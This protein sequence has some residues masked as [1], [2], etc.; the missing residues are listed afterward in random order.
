MRD[1]IFALHSF[2][3]KNG[4]NES[5]V[6]YWFSSLESA[7]EYLNNAG[8]WTEDGYRYDD[9]FEY[10][11]NYAVIEKVYEGPMS[12]NEVISWWECKFSDGEIE[13]VKIDSPPFETEGAFNFCPV[14]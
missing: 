1:H 4:R 9:P 3:H 5:G 13:V 8:K 10:R 2:L 11:W 6:T 12:F 14:G 7:E